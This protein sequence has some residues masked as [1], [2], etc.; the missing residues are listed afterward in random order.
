MTGVRAELVFERAS[1]CPVA[2]AS[3]AVDGP[4]TDIS[5][6]AATE[7]RVTEQVTIAGSGDDHPTDDQFEPVFD[8]GSR[9]VYAF[10][11]DA[12]D[13]CICEH[14][15]QTVGPVTETYA[16]DGALHVTLH[17]SD[18][19][20]LRDLLS[21][22][23]ERFGDVRVEYLVRSR[24][25]DDAADLVPVDLRRLTERQRE[26]LETAHEMGYFAYPRGANAGE[27]ATA[28]G[29]GTSTFT[30]HLNAAQSKLLDDLLL[31]D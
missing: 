2:T 24:T 5:W 22:L 4:A 23:R 6:T 7:N 14:I 21:D 30:E 1:D 31:R 12:S 25:D 3:T 19:D 17:A 11:R 13:P 27:V 15:E 28:L 10:E 8:Y 9:Q 16:V 20:M 26:V 29:I 18:V